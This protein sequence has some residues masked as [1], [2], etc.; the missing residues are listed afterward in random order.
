MRWDQRHEKSFTRQASGISANIPLTM[1]QSSK[2][3]T[4]FSLLRIR[5]CQKTRQQSCTYSTEF[6]ENRNVV[7]ALKFVRSIAYFAHYAQCRWIVNI[8]KIGFLTHTC[9]YRHKVLR[10][11]R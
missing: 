11:V 9:V 1:A 4:W 10:S 5:G 7:V 3:F 6:S 8:L 2:G